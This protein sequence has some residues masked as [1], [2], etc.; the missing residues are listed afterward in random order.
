M[1]QVERTE[2]IWDSFGGRIC[3]YQA[4]RAWEHRLIDVT[5]GLEILQSLLSR[6]MLS[7]HAAIIVSALYV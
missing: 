7:C 4:G 5:L 2:L 3:V 1:V 6:K